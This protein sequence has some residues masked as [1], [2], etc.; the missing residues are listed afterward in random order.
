MLAKRH[1]LT[2]DGI[3]NANPQIDC[4]RLDVGMKI[5]IPEASASRVTEPTQPSM[6]ARPYMPTTPQTPTQPSMPAR[7]SM[8]TTPQT[9]T[10]PSMPARPSMPTTPQTPTQPSM[11]AR[12]SM[13]T[14]P[15]T[16][17]QPSM[18]ARPS[19]PTTPQ[20]PTQPS[21]PARPSMPTTPQAPTQPKEEVPACDGFHYTIQSGDTLYMLA[22][23]Y[24]MSLDQLMQ[25]NPD[26]DPYNL[27]IGMIICIPYGNNAV[28]TE[29]DQYG[30]TDQQ[31]NRYAEECKGERR[32][33]TQKRRHADQNFKPVRHLLCCIGKQ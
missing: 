11:P 2:L 20:T 8:P 9:P 25:A 29:N 7:P 12:P 10:Q 6:P 18:P 26:L 15:Q 27:R 33:Q 22:K 23:R 30:K 3:M 28:Q 4:Y 5:C 13:P 1:G 19:M 31:S 24:Q 17:T 21:M 32:Y 14:T 16:P